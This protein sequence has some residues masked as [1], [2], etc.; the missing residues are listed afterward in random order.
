MSLSNKLEKACLLL[1][2][3]NIDISKLDLVSVDSILI[4]VDGTTNINVKYPVHLTHTST[5]P[6]GMGF[7]RIMDI[8][9]EELGDAQR[10]DILSS[11]V[12][13][14]KEIKKNYNGKKT[15]LQSIS[16]SNLGVFKEHNWKDGV[17]EYE[18]IYMQGVNK[19]LWFVDGEINILK[20]INVET[21]D[22]RA[23]EFSDVAN[24][25]LNLYYYISSA[26]IDNSDDI[27]KILLGYV[28]ERFNELGYNLNDINKHIPAQYMNKYLSLLSEG[29]VNKKHQKDI[30]N[31]LITTQFEHS[32]DELFDLLLSDPKYQ[33]IDN[34]IVVEIIDKIIREN[35]KAVEDAKTNPKKIG[36][37][38]GKI[39]SESNGQADLKV[40]TEILKEKLNIN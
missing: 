32:P 25:K 7:H 16:N 18:R 22:I 11:L 40:A 12:D 39:K 30:I 37:L 8:T 9:K 26:K 28:S 34:S 4:Y 36:F 27:I 19:G 31:Y 24:G 1:I 15:Y 5:R 10:S 29:K 38:I 35:E 17:L 23:R 14:L 6:D 33:V 3:K 13:K 21:T 20:N 2:E